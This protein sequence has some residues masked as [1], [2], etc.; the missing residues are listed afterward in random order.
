MFYLNNIIN[1][2]IS[3]TDIGFIGPDDDDLNWLLLLIESYNWYHQ[4]L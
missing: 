2:L 1:S 3:W 4:G